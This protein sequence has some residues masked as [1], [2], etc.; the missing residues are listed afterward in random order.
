MDHYSKESLGTLRAR[1]R[2]RSGLSLGEELD[3]IIR[4]LEHPEVTW[5]DLISALETTPGNNQDVVSLALHGRTSVP[6]SNLKDGP[7]CDA[8]YWIDLLAKRGI[9]LNERV[10]SNDQNSIE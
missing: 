9:D 8:P 7:I 10:R 1:L 5:Q 2:S 4:I 6:W 3:T